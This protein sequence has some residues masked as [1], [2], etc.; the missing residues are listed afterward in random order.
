M[1]FLNQTGQSRAIKELV[2]IL[3]AQG[4]TKPDSCVMSWHPVD[5]IWIRCKTQSPN[6]L[7]TLSHYHACPS[8]PLSIC[9]TPDPYYTQ[10]HSHPQFNLHYY[11]VYTRSD[12][13]LHSDKV[14]LTPTSTTHGNSSEIT[15]SQGLD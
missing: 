15:P 12:S 6:T 11:P 10:Q 13:T 4:I 9:I 1:M 2:H 14:K 5:S 7:Q 3:Y 8:T